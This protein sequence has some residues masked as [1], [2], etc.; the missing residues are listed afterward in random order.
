MTSKSRFDSQLRYFFI[1]S[2]MF[3]TLEDDFYPKPLTVEEQVL[4]NTDLID[5]SIRSWKTRAKLRIR[6]ERRIAK[7]VLFRSQKRLFIWQ[8]K[9]TK[10]IY[11]LRGFSMRAYYS[12]FNSLFFMFFFEVFYFFKKTFFLSVRKP[13]YRRRF[14]KRVST[15]FTLPII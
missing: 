13:C 5:R 15:F 6:T 11:M 14:Y 10:L 4:R 7:R 12:F 3:K 9:Q 2:V 8:A 1:L